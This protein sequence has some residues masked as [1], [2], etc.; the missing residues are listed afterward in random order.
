M[1]PGMATYTMLAEATQQ[2]E[3]KFALG[4][5][6]WLRHVTPRKTESLCVIF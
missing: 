1:H 5:V 2:G 3:G 6:T 4:A